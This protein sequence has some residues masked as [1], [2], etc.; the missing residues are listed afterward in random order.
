MNIKG[1]IRRALHPLADPLAR[2]WHKRSLSYSAAGE[3]QIVLG[4][5]EQFHRLS[6]GEVRYLDIGANDPINNSNTFL[7]YSL[8]AKGVLVEPNP[9][10]IGKLERTR[11]R[12]TILNVGCAFDERRSAKLK[13]L[14]SHVFS[15][16]VD[17]QASRIVTA[18][19]DWKSRQAVVDEIEVPLISANEIIDR[20]FTDGIDFISIDAEGVDM[21]ILK[22]IDLTRFK[23]KMIC[24]EASSPLVEFDAYL[25]Q[26][27]YER[28]ARTPDNLIYLSP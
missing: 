9:E 10:S 7:F 20:H 15:T 18:S 21:A 16:F 28:F 1:H 17:A 4:W 14:T 2:K 22:S 26:F 13:R 25:S 24:V 11:K 3:D 23:A 6:G 5:L 8:G 19:E 27:G 12:D